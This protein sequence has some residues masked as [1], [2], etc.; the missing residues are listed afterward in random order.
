MIILIGGWVRMAAQE[1]N[2]VRGVLCGEDGQPFSFANVLLLNSVDSSFLYGGVT[3]NKGVFAFSIQREGDLLLKASFV[4]CEDLFYSINVL[5]GKNDLG[6]LVLQEK[7][8]LLQDVTI[9][10][11]RPSITMRGGNIVINV[12][13]S[14]L[15]MLGTAQDMMRYVPGGIRLDDELQVSGKGNP[16]IYVDGHKLRDISEL[17]RISSNDIKSVEVILNP[18]VKYDAQSRAVLDIKTNKKE[19]TGLY[20]Y[21]MGRMEAG[22]YLRNRQMMNLGY[23][24]GKFDWYLSYNHFFSNQKRIEQETQRKEARDTTVMQ[25]EYSPNREASE[26]HSLTGSFNYMI[27]PKN[28]VG[29]KYFYEKSRNDWRVDDGAFNMLVNEQSLPVLWTDNRSK[30][31]TCMHQVNAFYQGSFNDFFKVQA[32]MDYM[33]RD[34]SNVAWIEETKDNS[35]R[36]TD[37]LRDR[38]NKLIAGS[39]DLS[40]DLK[41]GGK[42]NGGLSIAVWKPLEVQTL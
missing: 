2:Q 24:L 28:F 25:R 27:N 17:D 21:G 13:N 34:Y 41:E 42:I 26:S 10:A 40:Y 30:A 35:R 16:D 5:K 1:T 4:G 38:G 11:R 22:H 23:S 15:S 32:D 31:N 20:V 18:G 7:R 33:N 19:R 6:K 37:L 14:S 36:H 3:D 9:V 39:L 12:Q 8:T 29:A